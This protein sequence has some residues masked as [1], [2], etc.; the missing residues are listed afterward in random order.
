M[1]LGGSPLW[2]LS[3]RAL[4]MSVK[5]RFYRPVSR[6]TT[7][8]KKVDETLQFIAINNDVLRLVLHDSYVSKAHSA[9]SIMQ[10][11]LSVLSKVI[12]FMKI[13]RIIHDTLFRTYRKR[14]GDEVKSRGP[15]F[16]ALVG[17]LTYLIFAD[18]CSIQTDS[19]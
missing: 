3:P 7:L 16:S 6:A 4:P 1:K 2:K 15:L 13:T 11:D 14:I 5:I 8:H 19:K 17:L 12:L 18:N 10:D 9:L